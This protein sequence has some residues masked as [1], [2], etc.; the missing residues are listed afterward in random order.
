MVA[1]IKEKLWKILIHLSWAVKR[2]FRMLKFGVA[3][4]VLLPKPIINQEFS[5]DK[6]ME[7]R[8]SVRSFD[9]KT[10]TQKQ[11]S[12]LLWA[13]QGI[14]NHTRGLRVAP[15]AGALYP[16]Q[17]YMVKNDGVWVYLPHEHALNRITDKDLRAALSNCCLQQSAI[18]QAALNLVI[19]ADYSVVAN[20]YGN[21]AIRYTHFEVGH[22]AQ[23]I[24][25]EVVSLGLAAVPIGA[26]EDAA[27]QKL[28]NL[29]SNQTA[30]YVIAVGN[31]KQHKSKPEL[32]S[33]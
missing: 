5:L 9:S 11:I 22:V 16:L 4:I 7:Q 29:P 15:S 3:V 30:L 14:T 1:L 20:K 8:R 26:L 33:I 21:R 6:A 18:K 32:K 28:L 23:N 25:L 27:V 12:Q 31:P 13:A 10:L 2:T 17:L 19:T 24:L